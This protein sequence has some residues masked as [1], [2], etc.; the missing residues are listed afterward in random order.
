MNLQNK[1]AFYNI[2]GPIILNGIG[3]FT[4]PFFTRVLG[5]AQYGIVAVYKTWVNI[6]SI[7]FGL[8]TQGSIGTAMV[9]IDKKNRNLYIA[10]ILEFSLA[11]S[12]FCLLV[13]A[14]FSG[15]ISRL[16]LLDTTS[17]HLLL[18]QSV[19]MFVIAF[20]AIVFVFYKLANYSF[21]VN[22]SSALATASIS[23][24]L[25]LFRF[26]KD[27]L[28]LGMF[29]GMTVPITIIAGVLIIYFLK[30]GRYSFNPEYIKFCLPICLPIIFHAL[31]H[32]VLGQSDRVMLQRMV[33]NEATGIYSFMIT[34][35]GVLVT[36][37][38]ALNNTWVPFYYD[39]LKNG[40]MEKIACKTKNYIYIYSIIM[41]VFLMWAPEVIKIFAPPTFWDAINLLP[42]FVFSS[43]FIFLY[44]FPVN[45]QFFHKSTYSIAVGTVLAA[46][47]NIGLNFYFIPLWGAW[48]AAFT[49]LIAHILL[50]VFHEF[51]ADKVL[52]QNYHYNLKTFIPGIGAMI[53]AILAFEVLS[54]QVV[55]R[56]LIGAF[57]S[58]MFFKD[59]YYRRS[60]F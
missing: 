24:Y 22:V 28:Y 55:V 13:A 7:I 10:T 21:L 36:I 37:W 27:K 34:F 47:V 32:I 51:I 53:V 29:Y 41:I 35:S 40:F 42:L 57:L 15:P 14:L 56:W 20:S 58:I 43:Y 59:I 5:P 1:N 19:G 8:Q 38:S 3:F 23:A 16:L 31:A 6:F 39:D 2:L 25:V 60:I 45:F 50:F 46:L 17:F 18:I 44:S 49:T 11:F 52:K 12:L 48:G 54:G 4:M 9:Y 30:Q 33:G 26:P